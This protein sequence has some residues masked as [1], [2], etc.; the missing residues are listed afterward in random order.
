MTTGRKACPREDTSIR[1]E[2]TET[3]RFVWYITTWV[4]GGVRNKGSEDSRVV[5]D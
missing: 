4:C 5:K 2:K 1:D 3:Q